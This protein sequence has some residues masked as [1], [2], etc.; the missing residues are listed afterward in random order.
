MIVPEGVVR[1]RLRRAGLE[2][3]QNVQ[4]TVSNTF[5]SK[6]ATIT[7]KRC[8]FLSKVS[9]W[10]KCKKA[11]VVVRWMRDNRMMMNG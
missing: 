5:E 8:M 7:I 1:N 9:G 11:G 6:G 4:R 2:T 10:M 3:V